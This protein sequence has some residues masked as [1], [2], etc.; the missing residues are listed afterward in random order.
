[1]NT[2]TQQIGTVITRLV[3]LTIL[4][5]PLAFGAFAPTARAEDEPPYTIFLPLISTGRAAPDLIFTPDA[6]ELAPGAITSV[7]V[8]VEPAAD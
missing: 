1:M 8:R 5:L 2:L 4:A 3:L 6:V 7:A